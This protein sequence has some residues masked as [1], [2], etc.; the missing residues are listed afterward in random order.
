MI[1]KKISILFTVSSI[2]CLSACG[3]KDSSAT[4]TTGVIGHSTTASVNANTTDV[5]GIGIT[6]FNSQAPLAD[7]THFS[8]LIHLLKVFKGV[9]NGYQM[10]SGFNDVPLVPAH[11]SPV[12]GS[13]FNGS[14]NLD[15]TSVTFL[16]NAR[17]VNDWYC[18]RTNINGLA[19]SRNTAG[20]TANGEIIEYQYE[21][22]INGCT[23]KII[24][25]YQFDNMQLTDDL[26][27]RQGQVKI[28]N[29][30]KETSTIYHENKILVGQK[31]IQIS[32]QFGESWAAMQANK[33]LVAHR[34]N[35]SLLKVNS[36]LEN[37]VNFNFNG[38][39]SKLIDYGSLNH[40]D[41]LAATIFGGTPGAGIASVNWCNIV[42]IPNTLDT[43]TFQ[44]E[45][46]IS[47]NCA[48]AVARY[49]DGD[50]DI[51]AGISPA[52]APVAWSDE[53]A[54]SAM[55]N[56]VAWSDAVARAAM[57]DKKRL[58]DQGHFIMDNMAQNAF[59]IKAKSAIIPVFGYTSARTDGHINNAGK[60]SWA[61]HLGHCQN[62]MNS[63]YTEIGVSWLPD[64]T[65]PKLQT[66]W[67]QNFR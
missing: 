17:F 40:D 18:Y 56:T 57:K 62:V 4:N 49:C 14:I 63:R 13:D 46:V 45:S 31:L 36:Q 26:L 55:K 58:Q 30:A 66:Y 5:I 44:A 20:L 37:K 24:A 19:L 34:E 43:H 7:F 50:K 8:S 11:L 9:T 67:T 52:V 27:I 38:V 10:H 21:F 53:V 48:R 42:N 60:S 33:L 61:G 25:T 54:R 12:S 47:T 28:V 22:G 23:N 41:L 2:L 51:L 39:S 6:A 15:S 59:I 16:N 3:G 32:M 1:K 64:R 35:P 29:N 65:N